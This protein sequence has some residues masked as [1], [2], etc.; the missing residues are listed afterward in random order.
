MNRSRSVL[1]S[2]LALALGGCAVGPDYKR[3]ETAPPANHRG[4]AGAATEVSLA[5]LAWWD[6]AKD[7]PVLQGLIAEALKNNKDL[8]IAAQR[9]EEFRAISNV[10]Y[11]LPRIDAFAGANRQRS[12]ENGLGTL[13]A[14]SGTVV[15]GQ[16][17]NTFELSAGF[18]WE[19]DLWG[20]LR[21]T[22]ESNLARFL[23][24]EEARRG[25]YLGLVSE[26]ASAYYQLRALDLQLEVAKRTVASRKDSFDLVEKRLRGGI[27]N[28]LET[29]QAASALAQTEVALPQIEQAIFDQENLLSLLLGRSPG[30]IPRGKGIGELPADAI[31]AGLPS[32]L[33][34][35]RPDVREAEANLRAANAEVGVA[36]ANRLPQI[37]LT[38]SAGF[39]STDLST[40][41]QSPSFVWNLGGGILAPIFQG[42]RLQRGVDAARARWEQAR[43][44][45]EKAAL[46][47]FGDAASSL[48]AIPK[49]L[50]IR[51]AQGRNVDALREREKTAML[52]YDGG[53]SPYL[54]VLDAQRDLFSAELNYA[55][56]LRDQKLAVIRLYR[57]LGGGWNAPEKAPEGA[58]P[59]PPASAPAK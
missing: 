49:T 22:N 3:P 11:V 29:S 57:A 21:R 40:L 2:L 14:G 35:R 10:N 33:L 43:L 47:A 5:D 58:A 46:A 44:A 15:G 56:A 16:T 45:Y 41:L 50:E 55:V 19:I 42:G 38:G 27:G 13:V 26:V 23:A 51:A 34:E 4:A 9:V 1:A 37:N 28:K 8:G 53:V 59:S 48:Y 20:R 30:S 36:E 52:R 7:D 25:V 24:T 39:A 31:P 17:F 12:T 32:A 6:L 54:E 18:S